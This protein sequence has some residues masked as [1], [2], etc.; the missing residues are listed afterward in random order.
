MADP[1]PPRPGGVLGKNV[2]NTLSALGE[3]FAI[4]GHHKIAFK[5]DHP[6][7][8]GAAAYYSLRTTEDSN[9]DFRRDLLHAVRLY[10]PRNLA[11]AVEP[12]G[13]APDFAWAAAEDAV[14]EEL[15]QFQSCAMARL[16]DH[17]CTGAIP[18]HLVRT[19]SLAARK[20]PAAA[21][22]AAMA[23]KR[24]AAHAAGK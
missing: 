20:R 21:A 9:A 13:S 15:I 11:L 6:D 18:G 19:A 22:R 4:L 7:G 17:L 8:P 23:R 12:P 1:D 5:G 10:W 3:H 2:C 14:D 16:T 24:P